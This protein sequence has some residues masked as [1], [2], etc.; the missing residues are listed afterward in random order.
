MRDSSQPASQAFSRW[1]GC[2]LFVLLLATALLPW[3]RNRGYIRSFFD[4][5]VVIGATGRI[6]DGQ[7]PYVDFVTPMQA[8]FYAWN[9]LAERMGGG[10]FQAM[11]WSGA[12]GIALTMF[13]LSWALSRRWPFGISVVL[14]GA[15]TCATASQHTLLWYNPWGVFLLVLVACQSAIAPVLRGKH[16]LWHLGTAAGLVLGGLNKINMQL[17]AIA[18]VGG[19]AFRAAVKRESG[20]GRAGLT[21]AAALV[22][23]IVVPVW[24]EMLWT[25][26]SFPT[27]W[28]NV[29]A[30]MAGSRA[31]MLRTALHWEFFLKP[32]H[33]YYGTL[34]LPQIGLLGAVLTLA[35]TGALVRQARRGTFRGEWF[36]AVLCGGVAFCGGEV[37]LATNMDI[38]YIA[39]GGWIGLLLALWLGFDLRPSGPWF[40]GGL[41]LPALLVGAIAWQSAW[42]GQR[43]Q[44]GYSTAARSEYRSG[45][46]AGA[47]FGYLRDTRLPP[48]TVYAIRASGEWHAR[49]SESRRASLLYGPGSEWFAHIWPA[50]RTPELPLYILGGAQFAARETEATFAAIAQTTFSAILVA[51]YLD[52]WEPQLAE[53]LRLRYRKRSMGGIFQA[54]E[55]LEGNG[56]ALRPTEFLPYFGGN[57]DPEKLVSNGGLFLL[58]DGRRVVGTDRGKVTM[59]LNASSNR[60]NG[61]VVVQRVSGQETRIPLAA[62]FSIFAEGPGGERF[63]RWKQRVE[64]TPGQDSFTV[65]YAVDSSGLATRFDVEIAPALAGLVVAGWRGPSIQHTAVEGPETPRW[66]NEKDLPVVRLEPAQIARILPQDRTWTP[67]VGFLRGGR[68]VDDHLEISPGGELWLAV[69]GVVKDFSGSAALSGAGGSIEDVRLWSMWVRDARIEAFA[70]E[71]VNQLT[72]T[73]TFRCWGAQPNGWVVLATDFVPGAPALRLQIERAV[74]TR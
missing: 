74:A 16:W 52:V 73:T 66:I 39:M 40:W 29:I 56:F 57:T 41:F 50:P 1:I 65:D 30:Q 44:F 28:H 64:L 17:M 43:S 59:K 6:S 37:L 34:V 54:Y 12:A 36:F 32:C 35:T 71:R 8:G 3:W 69:D 51:E 31:G 21:V 60:V 47:D 55:T 58:S 49:L 46:E 27:W 2:L 42:L 24:L 33:D 68:L 5:G 63:P 15:L 72:G 7:K 70:G 48:E 62:D 19:W 14:A 53:L 11:T 26:A 45:D 13:G 20:W 23:G 25:G 4:Y 67:T 9:A 38:A 18:L 10:T 22:A 61:S